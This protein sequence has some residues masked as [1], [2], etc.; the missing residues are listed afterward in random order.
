MLD[1]HDNTTSI[2]AQ[3]YIKFYQQTLHMLHFYPNLTFL[4]SKI[5]ILRLF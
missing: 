2:Y 5:A 1:R 3:N 4:A